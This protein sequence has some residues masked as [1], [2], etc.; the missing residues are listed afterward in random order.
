MHVGGWYVGCGVRQA[1]G[2][3]VRGLGCEAGVWGGAG[4]G[5]GLA[6]HQCPSKRVKC[7]RIW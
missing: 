6:F 1:G 2:V 5:Q 3:E 4:V 7:I